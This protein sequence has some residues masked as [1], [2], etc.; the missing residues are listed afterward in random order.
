L[1]LACVFIARGKIA[2]TAGGK[3][4]NAVGLSAVHRLRLGSG[5]A[6]AGLSRG[7][8][9]ISRHRHSNHFADG[10]SNL[11]VVR[12]TFTTELAMEL[13]LADGDLE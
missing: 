13:L 6:A 8:L 1:L 5:D 2:E 12:P 4:Q 10:L 11:V 9:Q 7:Q 3:G